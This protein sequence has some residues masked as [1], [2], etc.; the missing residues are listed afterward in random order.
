MGLVGGAAGI[1]YI[2]AIGVRV[3]GGCWGAYIGA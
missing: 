1:A 3:A 2:V